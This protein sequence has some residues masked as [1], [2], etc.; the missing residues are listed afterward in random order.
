M[1]QKAELRARLAILRA[2]WEPEYF[3]ESDRAIEKR[4]LGLDGWKTA[5]TVFSYVSVRG[6]PLDIVK[7]T[8]DNVARFEVK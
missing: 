6:E 2:N 7:G 4:L 1:E 5:Q 3:R 8:R